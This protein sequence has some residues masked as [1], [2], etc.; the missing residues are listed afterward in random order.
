MHACA[1]DPGESSVRDIADEPV[2]ERELALVADRAQRRSADQASA[3]ELVERIVR[4]DRGFERPERPRPEPVTDHRCRLQQGSIRRCERVE[5]GGDQ[6]LHRVGD[7]HRRGVTPSVVIAVLTL[8]L[9]RAQA[10]GLRACGRTHARTTGCR[11]PAASA[12]PVRRR[13]RPTPAGAHRA[14]PA[15][16]GQ[17]AATASGSWRVR[18]P[19]P[20]TDPMVNNSGRGR[21]QHQERLGPRLLDDVAQELEHR[22]FGPVKIFDHHHQRGPSADSSRNLVH[23]AKDSA[24]STASCATPAAGPTSAWIRAWSHSR[25]SS[26]ASNDGR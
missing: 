3:L 18:C 10:R 21:A 13:A 17:K 12:N 9:H 20:T 2:G 6:G 8:R 7:V 16:R 15:C 1:G 25:S 22:G 14:A 4:I 5:A 11:P 26:V 23:A 19:F 24:R